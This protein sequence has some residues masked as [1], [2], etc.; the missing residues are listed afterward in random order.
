MNR[1]EF[2]AELDRLLSCLPEDERREAVQYYADYFADAGEENE[3]S[4][5]RELGSPEKVAETIKAD[6]FGKGFDEDGFEEKN[7]LRNNGETGEKRESDTEK[8]NKPWTNRWVKIG[9]IILII[10]AVWPV[11]AGIVCTVIGILAAV[12][13]FF[14]SL[15]L[16]SVC[17]MIA[18][19]VVAI[20]GIALIVMPPAAFILIGIGLLLFV[21][22]MVATAATVKLCII[23]Y[24]AMI[25]GFVNLCRRPFYGKAVS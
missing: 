25:R 21:L 1:R 13:C 12:V 9:L 19:A 24:P 17:I 8:E 14:A 3:A 18:G 15:V 4:V 20:C 10:I 7:H 2:L 6:Y 16:A 11:A 5:I 22:G 23:V